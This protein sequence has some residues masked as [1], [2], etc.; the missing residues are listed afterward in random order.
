MDAGAK[1]HAKVNLGFREGTLRTLEKDL[2]RGIC[3][4]ASL[5]QTIEQRTGDVYEYSV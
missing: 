1:R 5:R 2:N 3:P 4:Q